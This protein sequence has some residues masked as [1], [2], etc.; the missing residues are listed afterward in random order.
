MADEKK[1]ARPAEIQEQIKQL[2][3]EGMA[4]A[5]SE[6]VNFSLGDAPF[7]QNYGSG[8]LE[9]YSKHPEATDEWGEP[10]S[11]MTTG[12]GD[13]VAGRWMSSNSWGC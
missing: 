12:W 9:Y 3:T 8:G 4:I 6:G 1:I 10:V 2:T 5:D 7:A 13:E 11:E